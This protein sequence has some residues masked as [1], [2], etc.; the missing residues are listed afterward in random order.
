MCRGK[1]LFDVLPLDGME[2][3]GFHRGDD[4]FREAF[5]VVA[6][7]G[8]CRLAGTVRC[9]PFSRRFRRHCHFDRG[10]LLDV[11]GVD[12]PDLRSRPQAE[13]E[14]DLGPIR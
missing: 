4:R 11:L 5:A 8:W 13:I 12:H 2:Q 14:G 10:K 9:R 7:G 3:F 1:T 6:A